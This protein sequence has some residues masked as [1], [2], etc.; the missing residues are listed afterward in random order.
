MATGSLSSAYAKLV[1]HDPSDLAGTSVAARG[2]IDGDGSVDVVVGAPG[3]DA[4]AVSAGAAY[5]ALG[6]LSGTSDLAGS[7]QTIIGAAGN[8]LSAG[9]WRFRATSTR[10]ASTT[11]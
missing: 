7:P 10:T 4:G 1:G 8:E 11:C 5:L 3:D 2:D 6:P 9:R